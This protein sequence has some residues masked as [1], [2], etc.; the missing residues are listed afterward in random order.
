MSNSVEPNKNEPIM[1]K[2]ILLLCTIAGTSLMMSSCGGKYNE[3]PEINNG[4]ATKFILPSPTLLS[5][6]EKEY[7]EALRAEY[8][9]SIANE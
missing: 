1:K 4:Y 8:N 3:T 6:S 2:Y 9:E 5:N 7:L